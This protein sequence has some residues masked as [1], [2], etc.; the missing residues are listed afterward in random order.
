MP[1]RSPGARTTCSFGLALG[2]DFKGEAFFNAAASY[3]RTW[4]NTLGA[5]WRTDLQIGKTGLL[6][7]E[8]YQPLEAQRIFFVAPSVDVER[9]TID[10]YRGSERLAGYNVRSGL[11]NLDLGANLG[12]YGEV[13]FGV[14]TGT[15]HVDLET[16]P[17]SFEPLVDHARIGGI[18]GR[19]VIDQL[20]SANFPRA[21]YAG[22]IN[23]FK[24][25]AALGA[26]DNTFTR[27]GADGTAAWSLGRHTLSAGFKVGGNVGSGELPAY[28]LYQWGGLLQQSGY[29]TGALLGQR[30]TFGRLVYYYKAVDTRIFEGLYLGGSLEAGRM[31]Q[32]FVAGSPTG[33]LKSTALFAG[34]DT[35]VG[36]LYLGY[37]FAA[38]GN[39]SAY[40]YLGRP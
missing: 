38:D 26:E 11:A 30:L 17:P 35:P 32:P 2:S 9:R 7:T 33:V 25:S 31:E 6:S 36:P 19:F 18:T 1:S 8:F 23:I 29:P 5:E 15:A 3:R 34:F 20:D 16:G 13:R 10:L 39:R 21:G 14:T 37:G 27:L 22:A 28:A 40:L 4:L 12:E 24:S